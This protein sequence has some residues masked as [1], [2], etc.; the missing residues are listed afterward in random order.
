MRFLKVS[1]TFNLVVFCALLA[2]AS[3]AYAYSITPDSPTPLT[4]GWENDNDDIKDIVKEYLKNIDPLIVEL[5]KAEAD[6]FKEE[7]SLKDSFE[8]LFHPEDDPMDATITNSGAYLI[9]HP[10]LVVKDGKQTPNEMPP[11]WYLFELA[12][13]DGIEEL[14][15][16]G[17]WPDKGAISYVALYGTAQSVPEP[18]TMLLLGFGLIGLAGIGR[19][20]FFKK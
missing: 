20:K 5:Y 15:L 14:Q 3:Q 11:S 7:G 9:S 12:G 16:T 17:F 6:P 19:R 8:T 18:S 10:Y 4:Y 13:W 1:S 2:F